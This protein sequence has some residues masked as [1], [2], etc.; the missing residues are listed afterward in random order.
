[1]K[2]QLC[3]C[4]SQQWFSRC[5]EPFLKGTEIASTPEKLMRSRYS[6]YALGGHGEYLLQTWFA[7]MAKGLSANDLSQ[8]DHQWLGL[9]VLGSGVS[10]NEG[11]VEFKATYQD[12][13]DVVEMHE[14]SVFTKVANRWFYIGGEVARIKAPKPQG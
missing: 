7:P 1:M 5:C 13:N 8:L 6:A 14:K 12:N 11:W 3:I 2:N 4:G 9:I 10:G